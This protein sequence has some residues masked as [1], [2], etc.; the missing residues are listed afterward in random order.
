LIANTGGID[1]FTFPA[2]DDD[3]SRNF[4]S[5]VDLDGDGSFP[6][7]TVITTYTY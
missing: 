5:L 2:S 1:R 7:G 3:R 6:I 4:M